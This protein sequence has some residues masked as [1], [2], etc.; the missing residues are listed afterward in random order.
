MSLIGLDAADQF[1]VA[2]TNFPIQIEL[3]IDRRCL[4]GTDICRS[5]GLESYCHG[6]YN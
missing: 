1:S 2:F 4:H 5:A 6:G 3:G